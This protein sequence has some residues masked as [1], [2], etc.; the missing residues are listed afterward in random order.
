MEQRVCRHDFEK[1]L[2]GYRF[3]RLLLWKLYFNI[4]FGITNQFKYVILLFGWVSGEKAT[5]IWIIVIYLTFCFILGKAWVHFKFIDTEN[6]ISNLVN[7]FQ[8]EIRKKLIG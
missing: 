3:W 8:R 2:K 1:K 7:P 6:E 5:T 4:G